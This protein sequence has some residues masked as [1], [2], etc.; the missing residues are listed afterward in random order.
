MPVRFAM[1]TALISAVMVAL[2]A[3][4]PARPRWIRILLP[5]LAV[6][7][8]SLP[9][10]AWNAWA[11]LARGAV[12]V[13]ERRGSTGSACSGARTSSQFPVG[14]RGDSMIWQADSHFWFRMAGGYIAPKIPSSF[15]HPAAITHLTT[16]DNPSEVTLAAVL[17]PRTAE[18]RDQSRRRRPRG[19]D[20][21]ADP[22]APRPTGGGRWRR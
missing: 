10:L 19:G 15:M 8:R 22:G 16:G 6:V 21:A 7:L 5:A 11:A 3:S 12:P 4:S 18:R 9:N 13:H 2:W 14:S 20:L 1:Y 17:E